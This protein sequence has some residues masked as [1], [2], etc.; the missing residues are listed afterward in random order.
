[1]IKL[2]VKFDLWLDSNLPNGFQHALYS[3]VVILGFY[4]ALGWLYALSAYAGSIAFFYASEVMQGMDTQRKSLR[5][6]L[7]FWNWQKSQIQ[8]VFWVI[9]F[10]GPLVW[11]LRYV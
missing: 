10:G 11:L 1:M 3:I 6:A 8:D 9:V 4:F 7:Q 2:W 5:Y